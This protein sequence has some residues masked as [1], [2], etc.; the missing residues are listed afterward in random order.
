MPDYRVNMNNDELALHQQRLLMRSAQLRN[1]FASQAQ[2]FKAPLALADQIRGAVTWLCR[3]PYWPLGTLLALSMIR[4]R[5]TILWAGR[6]WWAWKMFK[7]ARNW[8]A[9]R[10]RQQIAS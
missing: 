1:A 9:T 8:I 3:N 4:P 10:P 5:R 6:L 7:R 2:D